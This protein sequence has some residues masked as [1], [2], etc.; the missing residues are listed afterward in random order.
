[1]TSIHLEEKISNFAQYSNQ[2]LYVMLS[3]M[4]GPSA[5]TLLS[6]R[7]H[8]TSPALSPVPLETIFR[9]ICIGSAPSISSAV[10]GPEVK[11]LESSKYR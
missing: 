5:F 4:A 1:M 6:S 7:S 9:V 8:A 3:S 11:S 2:S 10:T